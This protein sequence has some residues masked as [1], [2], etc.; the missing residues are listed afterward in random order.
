V[1]VV[2]ALI[3]AGR[4]RP[5]FLLA[6][7]VLVGCTGVA[8][9]VP[10]LTSEVYDVSLDGIEPSPG[11]SVHSVTVRGEL[12]RFGLWV[13][14][15]GM[16]RDHPVILFLH[17]AQRHPSFRFLG[18]CLVEPALAELSPIV[19]APEAPRGLGGEWWRGE[20]ASYALGLLRSV[21]FR[22]PVDDRR[23]VL[24]GYSNGGIGAWVMARTY[25]EYFSAAIPMAFNHTVVGETRV[26]VFAIQGERDELFGSSEIEAAVAGLRQHGR[27]VRLAILPRGSHYEPCSYGAQL[28]QARD[29]LR[30]VWADLPGPRPP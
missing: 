30:E 1:R 29:W 8:T 26:P 14:P 16:R 13:P 23:V 15:G 28:G 11:L 6:L 5:C 24:M 19:I 12:R 18:P 3:R 4:T 20:E 27:D 21:V 7:C 22:W 9:N 10:T 17:G 2:H 25:P